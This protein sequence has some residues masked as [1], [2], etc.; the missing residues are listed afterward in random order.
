MKT[1]KDKESNNGIEVRENAQG[2][3]RPA[4]EEAGRTGTCVAGH[5]CQEIQEMH[6]KE[7]PVPQWEENASVY[8][9]DDEGGRKD[10]IALC[11][12]GNGEGGGGL[13]EEF[14][15][16]E[17]ASCGNLVSVKAAGGVLRKPRPGRKPKEAPA[18]ISNA[19]DVIGVIHRLIPNFNTKLGE[20]NDPRGKKRITYDL[21]GEVWTVLLQ[22]LGIAVS[23]R[24]W[25]NVKYNG[26]LREN[27]NTLSGCSF[28]HLPH[29]D[30]IKYLLEKIEPREFNTVLT[31]AFIQLR[32]A[33]RL[34]TFKVDGQFYVAVDG[35]EFNTANHEIPHSCH[36]KLANGEVE[37][38]QVALVASIVTL[39]N[40]WFPIMVEFIENPDGEYDKQ[41][42]EYK[43]ALRLLPA[44]KKALPLQSFC[45]LMDALY[46]KSEVMNCIE[47]FSWDYVITWKD[48]VAPA[49]S[50]KAH[51]KIAQ[52]PQNRLS[53]H[54]S[55]HHE[56]FECA[57]ANRVTHYTADGKVDYTT[58]FLEVV[59]KFEWSQGKTTRFAFVTSKTI[60]KESALSILHAG[61]ERWGIETSNNVQKHSELNLESPY[62]MRGNTS[63]SYCMLVMVA[64]LVRCL[65]EHT[66]YFEKILLEESTGKTFGHVAG[67]LKKAYN[68]TMAFMRAV[69]D[70]LRNSRLNL[71]VL[72]LGVH[73]VF[74]SA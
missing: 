25:D 73:V 63:L 54:D 5:R 43:A 19:A 1:T 16:C 44:L 18:R 48:G 2:Q 47:N 69:C 15:S 50:K 37:Y 70:S 72:P 11:A 28:E 20:L 31:N 32:N 27:I 30:T 66:N 52:Y 29:S 67:A 14:Q 4:A 17:K 34:E 10:E 7:L 38:F 62:G 9:C 64:S 56:D 65:M 35:V 71:D 3:H 60:K 13:D 40:V 39:D 42:C 41:D 21:Q 74:N 6:G 45:M 24:D 55:V 23:S 51:S 61:R 57:W 22:R 26:V 46:H 33:K 49:L 58:N 68:S 12:G 59:G 8:G 53:V 36:R